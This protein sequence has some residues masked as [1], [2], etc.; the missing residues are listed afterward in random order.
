MQKV[1]T[2]LL[3]AALS[4]LVSAK[5]ASDSQKAFRLNVP[6]AWKSITQVNSRGVR[7]NG[8]KN[9]TNSGALVVT[10]V[11]LGRTSL[12]DWAK[13]TARQDSKAVVSSHTL[14]GTPARRLDFTTGEGYVTTIWLTAKNK[15][16]AM[17][18]LVHTKDCPDD[19]AAV[20]KG[21]VDSFQWGK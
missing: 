20:R 21:I 8:W 19:M 15:K 18:S 10:A 1:L 12:D 6:D 7:E 17:I 3:L 16:G 9:A 13:A 14:G 4:G 2:L 11:T 5:L